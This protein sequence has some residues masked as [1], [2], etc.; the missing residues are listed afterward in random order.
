[1]WVYIRIL[2]LN[3]VLLQSYVVMAAKRDLVHIITFFHEGVSKLT[4]AI[5]MYA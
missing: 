2:M 5:K 3:S 1:M 4:R